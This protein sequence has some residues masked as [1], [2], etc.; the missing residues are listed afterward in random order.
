MRIADNK[1]LQ[2]EN[3]FIL[4]QPKD[5]FNYPWTLYIFKSMSDEDHLILTLKLDKSTKNT[6]I[7]SNGTAMQDYIV[8]W[9]N[10]VSVVKLLDAGTDLLVDAYKKCTNFEE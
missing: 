9:E 7:I 4:S 5:D 2:I 8:T 3:E 1:L 6:T 10:W